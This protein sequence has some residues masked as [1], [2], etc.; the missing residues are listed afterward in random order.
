MRIASRYMFYATEVAHSYM[1]I[2][3]NLD[4]LHTVA[5]KL[6]ASD[7]AS[8]LSGIRGWGSISQHEVWGYR[9][10]RHDKEAYRD[11]AGTSAVAPDAQALAFFVDLNQK[12]GVLR[13]FSPTAGAA[14]KLN[15]THMLPP[16]KTA[17]TGIWETA[18]SLLGDAASNERM[19][20]VMGLFGFGVYV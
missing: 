10:Y 17:G 6:S 4:D 7:I 16:F 9:R 1:L 5:A 15:A 19:G 12:T 13:L 8:S 3:N 18:V 11:A 14:D 2:S 20:G